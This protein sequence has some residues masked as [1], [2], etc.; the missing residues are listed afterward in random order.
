MAL[1]PAVLTC[2]LLA[3][4]AH[5]APPSWPAPSGGVLAL[6]KDKFCVYEEY[7]SNHE[8]ALRLLVELNKAP[9]AR[10]FLLVSVPRAVP[11]AVPSPRGAPGWGGH[12]RL[13]SWPVGG[14]VHPR[15]PVKTRLMPSGHK[16]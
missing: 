12:G 11:G 1:V 16:Y 6:Q 7:C 2:R 14:L 13:F 8:K 5:P 10:A 4:A 9:A 3:S 15:G